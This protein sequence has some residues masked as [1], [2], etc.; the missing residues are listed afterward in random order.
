MPPTDLPWPSIRYG[1]RP[2]D[3]LLQYYGFVETDNPFDVFAIQQEQLL[4]DLNSLSPLA[5]NAL[6]TL[7]GAGLTDPKAFHALSAEGASASA[8]RLGRLAVH[9]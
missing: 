8:L 4:L 3:V 6:P 2:N 1:A 5:S 7:G 9:Q